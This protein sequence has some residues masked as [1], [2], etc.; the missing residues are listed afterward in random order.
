MIQPINLQECAQ[1]IYWAYQASIS[2]GDVGAT[3]IKLDII[4]GAGNR[5]I[6]LAVMVGPDNY[7]AGRV[8]SVTTQDSDGDVLKYWIYDDALDN[9]RISSPGLP[10]AS[11]NRNIPQFSFWDR[12]I[13]GTDKLSIQG[14]SLAQNET[15]EITIRALVRSIPTCTEG[16]AG[17]TVTKTERY[18]KAL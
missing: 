2:Q 11:D 3:T 18:N 4:P 5:M 15:I 12:L 8:V 10:Q 17:T 1:W 9:E 14:V 6:P 7:A 13:A 16:T